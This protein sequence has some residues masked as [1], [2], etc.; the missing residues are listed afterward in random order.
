VRRS[1]VGK[2]AN[3]DEIDVHN[4]QLVTTSGDKIVIVWPNVSMDRHQALV[5]A[6][7]LVALVDDDEHFN[8]ILARVREVRK[9]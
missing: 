3:D 4:R 5:H 2:S 9:R 7:W 6:A 8:K 1:I